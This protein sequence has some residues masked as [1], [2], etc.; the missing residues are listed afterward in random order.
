MS[1]YNRKGGSGKSGSLRE[2]FN[3][4]KRQLDRRLI[5]EQ[6]FKEARRA[7]SIEG[8]IITLFKDENL[9]YYKVFNEG[10]TRKKGAQTVRYVGEEA[11]KIQISSL[12]K[13]AS[14]TYQA[15]RFIDN[16]E[17]AMSKKGFTLSQINRADRLLR[18]A[19][20]DKLTLL[21]QKGLV[22]TPPYIYALY[23]YEEYLDDLENALK[24][25]VTSEELKEFR[26]KKKALIKVITERNKI[27]K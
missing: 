3:Y 18:S 7:G 16:V 15:E 20:I 12:K 6:A 5:E 4:Y 14:K 26:T 8:R 9:N 24:Y 17:I 22:K 11:V 19:S 27:L 10:I 25:G 1:V 23:T 21:I 13:R 2:Q